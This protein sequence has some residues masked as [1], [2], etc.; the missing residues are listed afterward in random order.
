MAHATTGIPPALARAMR[1]EIQAFSRALGGVRE[2]D[3]ARQV[4]RDLADAPRWRPA[5][6][7]RVDR[8]C[9]RTR[10]RREKTMIERLA[11]PEVDT[12][13]ARLSHLFESARPASKRSGAPTVILARVRRRAA[14]L[15][16]AL[17][18]AGTMYAIEPLHR[19][20]IAAKKLRY[21]LEIARPGAGVSIG[22][23]I[24]LVKDAQTRLG[25]IHDL[26]VLQSR[27]QKA[28]SESGLD[29]ATTRQL[30]DL[31]RHLETRCRAIHAKFVKS[32]P[33]VRD[34][35]ERLPAELALRLV[36]ARR[37]RMARMTA[38]AVLPAAAAGPR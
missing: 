35:A 1:R 16:R 36:H 26:Q 20:R 18:A 28:A 37:H 3:V 4:L 6:L 14:A 27:V 17:E 9:E 19:L 8:A 7:A 29:R 38:A 33:R 24:R 23:E 10:R 12:V 31:D 15:E 11:D 21:A 25:E 34:L 13:P 30:A 22:R 2:M 32:A 5:V